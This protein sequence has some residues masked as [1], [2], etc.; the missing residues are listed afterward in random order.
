MSLTIDKPKREPDDFCL[1]CKA[2]LGF[3]PQVPNGISICVECLEHVQNADTALHIQM[4]K[5][6]EAWLRRKNDES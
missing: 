6:P 5:S 3:N 2:K 1:V 4:S